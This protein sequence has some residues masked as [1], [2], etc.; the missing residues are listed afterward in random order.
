MNHILDAIFQ[1]RAVK[2][3]DPVKIPP[4]TR[5]QI[6][7]AARLAPSSF[8]IQPYRFYW[9]ETPGH[10]PRSRQ[11]VHESIS[12]GHRIGSRRSRRGS[13]IMAIDD[14]V[15]PRMDARSR[16]F[17]RENR[18]IRAEIQMGQMVFHPGMVRHPRSPEM[19]DLPDREYL[20]DPWLSARRPA[21]NVQM[22]H[23]EHFT[24]LRKFDDRCR[25]IGAE[26]MPDGRI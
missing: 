11:A 3:F 15:L 8:N 26:Y 13:R 4:E 16:I 17:P 25:S 10:P 5:E 7:E 2:V 23:E 22:G 19:G 18:R 1:R 20:E 9:I 6:L 14:P 24:R 21:G 12:R